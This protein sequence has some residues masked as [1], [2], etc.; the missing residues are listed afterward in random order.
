[1]QPLFIVVYRKLSLLIILLPLFLA[2]CASAPIVSETAAAP[3][4]L[5]FEKVAIK[6]HPIVAV[7]LGGGATRGF[8]HVGVLNTLE[9]N[10]IIPDIIVGTSAGAV[11]GVLFSGGIRG[12]RLEDVARQIHRDQIVDWSYSG[13]GFIRGE[14]LQKYINDL[15]DDRPIE[16]L[17]TVFAATATDLGSGNL[18]IFMKGDAGLAVRISSSIPG[19]VSPVTINGHDYV[20]GGLVSKV[21]VQVA[22][23]LGADI[24]IAVDISLPLNDHPVIDSTL[25]VMKQALAIMSQVV[26]EKDLQEADIVIRP[27]IGIVTLGDFDLRDDS[28]KAGERA[29]LD[30][31]PA[32]KQLLTKKSK[33]RRHH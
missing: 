27:A 5:P 17:E 29:A 3:Q 24:V 16:G 25:A 30:M 33:A 13:R 20:D 12:A 31:I 8:A 15:L 10:G 18:V 32:I 19:L 2:G 6:Q 9:K 14:L 4:T 23:D 7:A 1:V 26:A 11:T 21:P 28:I 22:R